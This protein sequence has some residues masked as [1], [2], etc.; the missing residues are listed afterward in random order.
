V[1]TTQLAKHYD[2]L[3]ADERVSLMVAAHKRR[4]SAEIDRLEQA[5]PKALYW[6][7]HDCGIRRGLVA[8]LQHSHAEQLVCALGFQ[9]M[10]AFCLESF[11]D[12]TPDPRWLTMDLFAWRLHVH[13][14]AW[15]LFSD[16]HDVDPD[17]LMEGQPGHNL[18]ELFADQV[19]RSFEALQERLA[20]C[21]PDTEPPTVD[22]TI[23]SYRTLF[24]EIANPWS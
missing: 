4:D 13:R 23:D 19:D 20:D 10:Y 17:T 7:R 15:R 21:E 14:E 6:V 1:N 5:A 12:A 16:E 2:T 24:S 9:W 18:V 3:T 8:V 11:D 22:E